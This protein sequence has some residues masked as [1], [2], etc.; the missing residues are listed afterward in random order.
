V[1]VTN[2]R[3]ALAIEHAA[4]RGFDDVAYAV[5][6]D[7]GWR[8]GTTLGFRLGARA[9]GRGDRGADHGR[10]AG[11]W[12]GRDGGRVLMFC[13]LPMEEVGIGAYATSPQSV[14]GGWGRQYFLFW[15]VHL[16]VGIGDFV[17]VTGFFVAREVY[18]DGKCRL[19][20]IGAYHGGDVWPSALSTWCVE[21]QHAQSDE[22]MAEENGN[23]EEDHDE[24]NVN[25]LAEVA[26]SKGD[27]E[28]YIVVLVVL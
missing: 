12:H 22:R 27:S 23:G 18:S 9:S 20:A 1:N 15:I 13:A 24:Y 4:R 11:M 17:D 3:A 8:S 7:V 5:F 19:E 2:A 6:G 25:F 14:G 28:V 21:E 10:E 26:I 16:W